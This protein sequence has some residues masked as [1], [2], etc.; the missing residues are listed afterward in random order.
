MFN[1]F[2]YF[3]MTKSSH[4][5]GIKILKVPQKDL[6]L[7]PCKMYAKLMHLINIFILRFT[8]FVFSECFET[9]KD[10]FLDPS[11]SSHNTC[12]NF[13]IVVSQ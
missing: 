6:F 12:F 13:F 8:L 1:Y 2:E 7:V 10:T 3:P 5:E 9:R 11:I 4:V